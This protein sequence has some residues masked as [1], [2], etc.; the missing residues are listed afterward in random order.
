MPPFLKMDAT[1][2]KQTI[3]PN[4]NVQ[5]KEIIYYQRDK[6]SQYLITF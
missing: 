4:N 2:K 5:L 6:I 1:G 3:G